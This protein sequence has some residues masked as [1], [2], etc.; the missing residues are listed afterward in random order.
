M[1][2][3]DTE[4]Q[5]FERTLVLPENLTEIARKRLIEG[6]TDQLPLWF[7][8]F[9]NDEVAALTTKMRLPKQTDW[10]QVRRP[11]QDACIVA[12]MHSVPTRETIELAAQYR[13]ETRELLETWRLIWERSFPGFAAN[14]KNEGRDNEKSTAG[15]SVEYFDRMAN[16]FRPSEPVKSA[17]KELEQFAAA[18]RKVDDVMSAPM[19][20]KRDYRLHIIDDAETTVA[21]RHLRPG[22]GYLSFLETLY[23]LKAH[24]ADGLPVFEQTEPC[25][26]YQKAWQ[27]DRLNDHPEYWFWPRFQKYM[28]RRSAY[29]S[30]LKVAAAMIADMAWQGHTHAFIKVADQKKGTWTLNLGSIRTIQ[31]GE[32][33]LCQLTDARGINPKKLPVV[34][35]EHVPFTH[36]QRFFVL[37]GRVVASVASDRHFCVSDA[38]ADRRLDERLAVLKVPSIDQGAYD[39]GETGHI[40]D[41]KVSAQFARLARKIA[42]DLREDGHL[43]YVVDLGLTDRGVAAVEINT[44]HYAG[45]Y[46]LEKKWLMKAYDRRRLALQAELDAEVSAAYPVRTD[47]PV[48]LAF[49]EQFK[50]PQLLEMGLADQMRARSQ[51]DLDFFKGNMAER[52]LVKALIAAKLKDRGNGQ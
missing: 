26:K 22:F 49:A 40:V 51:D 32:R 7:G 45:P 15:Y 29:A 11:M 18:W 30:D 37:D 27:P 4:P 35:Q 48:V 46:C 47:D 34:V 14:E 44:L 23:R 9:W 52:L 20:D 6:G 2:T 8:Q 19:Q 1:Q 13:P 16:S 39:R 41:R 17:R 10:K 24:S 33:A 50:T 5:N 12:R 28:S 21:F 38:S 42:R 3:I 36:E 31:D 25:D 43:D